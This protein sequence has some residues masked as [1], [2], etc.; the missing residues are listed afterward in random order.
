MNFK[1]LRNIFNN[2]LIVQIIFVVVITGAIFLFERFSGKEDS[3]FKNVSKNEAAL[4]IDFDNMKRVFAGKV[5][6]GMT[7][8]D[9]LNAAVAAGQIKLT[10]YVDSNNK[11][12]VTEI[13]DHTTNG[14]APFTFYINSRKLD[15]SDLNKTPIK[16]GNKITIRLE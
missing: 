6:D 4:F 2:T 1:K 5:V 15:P 11:T 3:A 9:A 13:N 10:Y 12:K 7:V 8:L 14:E 16:P